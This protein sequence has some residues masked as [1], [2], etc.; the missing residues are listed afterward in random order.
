MS[1]RGIFSINLVVPD[2]WGIGKSVLRDF[3]MV[4]KC[5]TECSCRSCIAILS[6]IYYEYDHKRKCSFQKNLTTHYES[7]QLIRIHALLR[8]YY[9]EVVKIID[10]ENNFLALFL[11]GSFTT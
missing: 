8:K 10:R 7:V 9:L 1:F 11:L 4:V 3:G 5:K 6:K 2:Y